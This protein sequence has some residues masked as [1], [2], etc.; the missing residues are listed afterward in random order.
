MRIPSEIKFSDRGQRNFTVTKLAELRPFREVILNPKNEKKEEGTYPNN[1]NNRTRKYDEIIFN[2]ICKQFGPKWKDEQLQNFEVLRE[3][4][5]QWLEKPDSLTVSSYDSWGIIPHIWLK[6]LPSEF[7][8]SV[9]PLI[10]LDML[11]QFDGVLL[12]THSPN[13]MIYVS[14]AALYAENAPEKPH[15]DLHRLEV[16]LVSR[17]RGHQ[18]TVSWSRM[19]LAA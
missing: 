14:G 18:K 8:T 3:K 11:G 6:Y 16:L 10:V 19:S 5:S 4:V 1:L 7:D 2:S 12:P 17:R 13:H 9:L 15:N